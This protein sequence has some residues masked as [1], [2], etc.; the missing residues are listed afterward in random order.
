[1]HLAST[2]PPNHEGAN[3]LELKAAILS[4][5]LEFLWVVLQGAGVPEIVLAAIRAPWANKFHWLTWQSHRRRPL[6]EVRSGA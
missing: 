4:M 6:L 5:V 3:V 1:M 2:G